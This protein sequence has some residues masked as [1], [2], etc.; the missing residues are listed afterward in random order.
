MKTHKQEML[1]LLALAIEAAADSSNIEMH[2]PLTSFQQCS[3]EN[4]EWHICRGEKRPEWY[5]P[6]VLDFNES[7][8]EDIAP[9]FTC[10]DAG[11]DCET[12]VSE[13]L[14]LHDISEETIFDDNVSSNIADELLT[15]CHD[16]CEAGSKGDACR[17]NDDH[18]S[19]TPGSH[20]CDFASDEDFAKN[21]S[22]TC[23]ACPLDRNECYQDGFLTSSRGKQNC[24][25]CRLVCSEVGQ[26]TLTVNGTEIPSSPIA[27][28]IQK[29]YQNV[30]GTL[31]DCSHLL[32][33]NEDECPGA[34]GRVCIVDPSILRNY[35][36]AELP[37]E[38]S[39]AAEKN[40]CVAIIAIDIY[41]WHDFDKLAIPFIIVSKEY[42]KQ[43]LA[44]DVDAVAQIE[45]QLF[46][47]TCTRN[48]FSCNTKLPCGDNEFCHYLDVVID[49]EYTEGHCDVCPKFDNGEPD[50]SRCFFDQDDYWDI[51]FSFSSPAAVRSCANSCNATL[52][53]DDCKFCPSEV[54]VIDFGVVT[55]AD[56]CF[57]CPNNDVLYPDEI[58]PL[59]GGNI[60]CWMLQTFFNRMHVRKDSSNCRLVQSMNYICGC[61]GTGYA[62][63]NT[64]TK[65]VVLVWLPRVAA[66]LSMVGSLFIIYDTLRTRQ[67][68]NK[69]RSQLLSTLSFFDILGSGAYA[70]TT[71][72]TPE[73]DHLFGA[74]GNEQSCTAQGFFIQVGTI[75]CF[76]NVSLA[77]YYLLTIKYGWTE[78]R[79]KKKYVAG[80]LFAPP[81]VIGLVFAFVATGIMGTL[82]YHVYNNEKRT[83]RYTNSGSR[84][85]IM[86][87]KQSCWFVIAFYITWV[88]YLTLQYMLSSGK[89]Y[90]NYGLILSAATLVPLQG[91]WNNIVYIRTRYLGTIISYVGSTSRRV[92]SY[93][94]RS[95][96]PDITEQ[97]ALE[98]FQ[99]SAAHDQLQVLQFNR[100]SLED[101]FFEQGENAISLNKKEKESKPLETTLKMVHFTENPAVRT[102][103]EEENARNDMNGNEEDGDMRENSDR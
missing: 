35:Q 27:A 10:P 15:S 90:D 21:V 68:R 13:F 41:F 9:C 88:P 38:L 22:G 79:M 23:I 25:N 77:L 81:I 78:E 96:N 47:S 17:S 20:F 5:C 48:T 30:S 19:C 34:E 83:S 54:S 97:S 40:G 61:N 36:V 98:S 60:T 14:E 84:L 4:K 82:C 64:H 69:L 57:F 103:S 67:K 52:V 56:Q 93:F 51:T 7:Q 53:S 1:L 43:W 75:A 76:L 12:A 24:A 91:F 42:A 94:Q 100:S 65:Q 55:E 46:G 29:S 71:L 70:L 102:F 31:I 73:S 49:D 62:G 18:D 3:H 86:V 85:S 72:P 92:S 63:A 16:L 66:F 101:T 89:G 50:P 2:N 8:L 39:D 6:T 44:S 59:F 80:S 33:E 11:S 58:V 28:A 45:V 99:Q 32:L 74:Q 26:S 87:F 95:S 37:W